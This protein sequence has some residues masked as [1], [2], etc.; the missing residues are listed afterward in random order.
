MG[1]GGGFGLGFAAAVA[2]EEEVK[3]PNEWTGNRPCRALDAVQCG[4]SAPL[5]LV[6]RGT[7][8]V[9]IGGHGVRERST[10]PSWLLSPTDTR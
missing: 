2:G 10:D 4:R 8:T 9:G 3:K 7:W 5:D 1:G 6:G